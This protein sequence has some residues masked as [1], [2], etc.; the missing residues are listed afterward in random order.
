VDPVGY[1]TGVFKIAGDTPLLA[2]EV[3]LF[4]DGV[5]AGK[6]RIRQIAPGAETELGF[7]R[8][9]LV[10]IIRREVE[11][12]AGS[13]GII[14]EQN[15]LRRLYVTSVENLHAF[16]VKVHMTDRM[17]YS[18]HEEIVVE[19]L[20]ETTKPSATEPDNRRGI[21]VWD[22]PLEPQAKTEVA[23]GYSVAHPSQMKVAIPQ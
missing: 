1:L 13:S 23:F 15:T 17:P 14:T 21:V 16:P 6:S 22:L 10:R 4:R 8:D 18:L 9:D 2:G 12:T 19:M 5:F 11:N 20:R 7:G 3:S